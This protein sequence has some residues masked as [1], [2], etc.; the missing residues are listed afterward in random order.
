MLLLPA[1]IKR[2]EKKNEN[3][4]QHRFPHYNLSFGVR[5]PVFGVFDLAPHKPGC[6][7][8]KEISDLGRRGIALSM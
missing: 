8:I 2:I 7:A 1:S 4:W 3:K 5:K 6:T